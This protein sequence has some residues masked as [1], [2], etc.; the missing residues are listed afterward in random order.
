MTNSTLYPPIGQQ[1]DWKDHTT[2]SG[3]YWHPVFWSAVENVP[4]IVNDPEWFFNR[5][6]HFHLETE[7]LYLGD[8]QPQQHEQP[9][10]RRYFEGDKSAIRDWVPQLGPEGTG[11]FI[12]TVQDSDDGP[13]V[14]WARQREDDTPVG[15]HPIK[16]VN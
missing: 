11:W 14:V 8:G 9:L 2:E 1:R 13:F 16:D 15:V 5:L 6:D 7:S 12:L 3:E 4:S 10:L